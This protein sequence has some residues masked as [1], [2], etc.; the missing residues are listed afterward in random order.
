MSPLAILLGCALA[1][2]NVGVACAAPTVD[3][4]PADWQRH[5]TLVEFRNL[6]K[7]YSCNELWYKFRDVLWRLG[8]SADID[9][10]PYR[11][12]QALGDRARSP[13][14]RVEYYVPA[15]RTGAAAQ[16]A[17]LE[18]RPEEIRIAPGDPASIDSSD[19]ALLRQM[20]AALP[21]KVVRF[22][23]ACSAPPATSQRFSIVVQTLMRVEE[24]STQA[25]VLSSNHAR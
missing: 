24:P 18:A 21:G 19:C 20:K 6:P 3:T 4:R 15:G 5:N 7:R 8:A 1:M 9:I 2:G 10:L 22:D 11:C 17:H 12:E 16:S 13:R 14:V 23:L 25:S